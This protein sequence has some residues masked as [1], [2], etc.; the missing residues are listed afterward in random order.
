MA[1]CGIIEDIDLSN[2][3]PLPELK[4]G[5][6]FMASDYPVTVTK[7]SGSNGVFTG[8]GWVM[9]RWI[10]NV[11]VAVEFENIPINT[12][13][14]ATGGI[15]NFKY[16][17]DWKNVGNLDKPN[18]GNDGSGGIKI[19]VTV[20][21]V[22][23][24]NPEFE[25]NDS[26]G[27][28]IIYDLS[29]EP[30]S[31]ELPKNSEGKVVFPVTV[32]DKD[33]NVY[34]INEEID[35]YGNATGKYVITQEDGDDEISAAETSDNAKNKI[36]FEIK[37]TIYNNGDT[38]TSIYNNK[39]LRINILSDE[40]IEWA[41][42]AVYI[43]NKKLTINEEKVDEDSI[44]HYVSIQVSTSNLKSSN[45]LEIKSVKDKKTLS[46]LKINTYNS[47]TVKFDRTDNNAVDHL[48]DKGFDEQNILKQKGE[49]KTITIKNKD[50]YVP[51]LGIVIDK[52]ATIKIDVDDFEEKIIKNDPN[53]RLVIK[54]RENN[55]IYIDNQNDSLVLNYEQLAIVKSRG[56]LN[57]KSKEAINGENLT[58]MFI[59]VIIGETREIVGQIEYYSAIPIKRKI[60]LIYTKFANSSSNIPTNIDSNIL[61]D[62]LNTQSMNQLFVEFTSVDTLH[63]YCTLKESDLE[64][65]TN[66]D[67]VLIKLNK[68]AIKNH[69]NKFASI[70]N[71][72]YKDIDFYFIT[73]LD[74]QLSG[75]NYL[76]G[77][78]FTGKKG[79]F[80]VKN[81]S[82]NET[83]YEI[84]AHELG[85]WL[86]L[87]HTFEKSNKIPFIINASKSGTTHNFM[88]Y[89][90]K[91]KRWFKIQLMNSIR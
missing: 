14:R 59:D 30:H 34:E 72:I 31:I 65:Y 76:S 62:F 55:K 40:N 67:S 20:D 85:H 88:D 68:D 74:I 25:Y 6:V 17:K 82:A 73:N 84:M 21:F 18:D 81:H 58:S 51:V 69:G 15:I 4:A 8:E 47:P 57:I 32:K 61:T 9:L 37:S 54:A 2:R 56:T 10:L 53:F 11:R 29:G 75:N 33:G 5:D 87:P 7:I 35:E 41:D 28:L 60:A 50:F 38:Y 13:K 46:T 83:D 86:G 79:G 45:K 66:P 91:R 27:V 63:F 52:S 48:F 22:I 44:V 12:D 64:K 89:N 80:S 43:K 42:L 1:N 24:P 19:D 70:L 3:E 49:Y 78:H 77:A 36:K 39:E 16:N 90:I 26:T 23:P 71:D